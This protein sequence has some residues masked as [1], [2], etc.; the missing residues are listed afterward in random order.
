[1]AN[2]VKLPVSSENFK[3]YVDRV[4]SKKGYGT[5]VTGTVKSGM[6]SNGDVVELLPDKNSS[7]YQRDTD[8]WWK[9][10]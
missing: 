6:I 3:L 1:M 4:F 2:T 10:K 7:N 8:P 5:I 9:Y